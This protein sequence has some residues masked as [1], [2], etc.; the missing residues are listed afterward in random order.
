MTGRELVDAYGFQDGA[1]SAALGAG[2]SVA[3]NG[4]QDYFGN[5]LAQFSLAADG[6]AAYTDAGNWTDANFAYPAGVW[7]PVSLVLHPATG[8]Y[9]LTVAGNH[10][11]T[12]RLT[13]GAGP[14]SQLRYNLPATSAAAGFAADDAFVQPLGC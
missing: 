8:S 13:P 2:V 12:A 4:G 7:L 11:A 1:G 9:D 10:L 5:P 6:N 14:A 3:G